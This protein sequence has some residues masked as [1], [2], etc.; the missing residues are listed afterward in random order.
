MS[1]P[2]P[3]PED[4]LELSSPGQ[5]TIHHAGLLTYGGQSIKL[6]DQA[7]GA[8]KATLFFSLGRSERSVAA[9]LLCLR[10]GLKLGEKSPK[11][12]SDK[13]FTRLRNLSAEIYAEKL[14]LE[15]QANLTLDALEEAIRAHPE[16]KFVII[17]SMELM[18]SPMRTDGRI[19]GFAR[20]VGQLR[21]RARKLR[22]AILCFRRPQL[23][24]PHEA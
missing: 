19:K 7:I 16:V 23:F 5:V 4:W 18:D 20:L 11:V 3:Q 9:D 17:D 24:E 15:D 13:E 2:I 12:F 22:V 21:Q 1:S 10:A 8:G 6:L 14:Y